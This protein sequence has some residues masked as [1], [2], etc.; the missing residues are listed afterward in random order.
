MRSGHN[1]LPEIISNQRDRVRS[2]LAY[3]DGRSTDPNNV[4]TCKVPL[5]EIVYP[6]Q[7]AANGLVCERCFF[8]GKVQGNNPDNSIGKP[9][10]RRVV[11][12]TAKD[13]PPLKRKVGKYPRDESLA[14]L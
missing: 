14:P 9:P 2:M 6:D 8:D 5:W 1:L 11:V 3:D 13:M 4:S 10:K 7:V 12:T